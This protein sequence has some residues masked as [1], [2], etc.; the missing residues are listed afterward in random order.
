MVT[1]DASA[2]RFTS[3][4][5]MIQDGRIVGDRRDELA[6]VEDKEVA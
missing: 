1:H 5:I 2:A 3:R 4:Q 6:R